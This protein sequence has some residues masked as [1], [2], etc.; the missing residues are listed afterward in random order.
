MTENSIR[1]IR[2]VSENNSVYFS[3]RI[4]FEG[5]F[6]LFLPNQNG[7]FSWLIKNVT[8]RF[9]K[10]S[11][12]LLFDLLKLFACFF[13]TIGHQSHSSIDRA[14]AK[15]QRCYWLGAKNLQVIDEPADF[16][17]GVA[18]IE[19]RIHVSVYKTKTQTILETQSTIAGA[20]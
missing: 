10:L 4:P 8:S 13:E 12:L 2:T 15:Y 7:W 16:G 20:V 6:L 14:Y 11:N 5:V 17:G 19:S 18:D 9:W 1:R 3:V